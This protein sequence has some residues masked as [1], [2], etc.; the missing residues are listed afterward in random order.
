MKAYVLSFRLPY[1]SLT[2]WMS[3]FAN[4]PKLFATTCARL[5][6]RMID[7]VPKGMKLTEV[8]EPLLAKPQGAQITVLANDTFA[9]R[10]EVR[11]SILF[12]KCS[13]LLISHALF[14]WT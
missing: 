5:F 14:R 4:S 6:A 3:S 2:S 7:T 1:T 8:I 9:L 12:L 13:L 11:V 10:G